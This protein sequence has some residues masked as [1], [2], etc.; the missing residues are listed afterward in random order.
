MKIK[1]FLA[2]VFSL[3]LFD[4]AQKNLLTLNLRKDKEYK[5]TILSQMNMTMTMFGQKVPVD[6]LNKMIVI[7]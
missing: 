7:D 1:Y 3:T 5:Q 2:V 6:M 4:Q